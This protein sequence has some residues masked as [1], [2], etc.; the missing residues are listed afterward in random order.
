MTL[1]GYT[2]V[3]TVDPGTKNV[4]MTVYDVR[5]R[6]FVHLERAD[7]RVQGGK[8]GVMSPANMRLLKEAIDRAM[9]SISGPRGRIL[10]LVENQ[11]LSTKFQVAVVEVAGA[12][13]YGLMAVGADVQRCSSNEKL[14]FYRL[15]CST[16]A[17]N[18]RNVDGLVRAW[19]EHDPSIATEQVR[20]VFSSGKSDDM[21]DCML[22]ALARM[23]VP[24]PDGVTVEST[25]RPPRKRKAE[26]VRKRKAE[27]VRKGKGIG[28]V[29]N[30]PARVVKARIEVIDLTDSE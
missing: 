25:P 10:A 21:A 29:Q 18:K 14:S 9:L 30:A 3:V 4:A 5:R 12:C 19:V 22:M 6:Q 7:V 23:R 1:D 28:A 27:V 20:A 15:M 24:K 2:H 17:K 11:Q 8:G 26:V 13:Q 16:R